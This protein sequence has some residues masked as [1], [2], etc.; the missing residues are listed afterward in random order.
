MTLDERLASLDPNQRAI[1]GAVLKLLPRIGEV[2][3][4]PVRVGLFLKHGSVFASLRL[5]RAGMRLLVMLPRPL[6]HPRLSH[7]RISRGS[8]RIPH[9]TTL[10][11]R[12][13]VDN[14]VMSWLAESYASTDGGR[15]QV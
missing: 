5:R 13:D 1:C 6:D 12:E 7:P 2:Q 4:E 8:S 14:T 15:G 3:V 11:G 9:S 10:R